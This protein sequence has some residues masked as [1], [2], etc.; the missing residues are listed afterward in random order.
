MVLE[1]NRDWVNS[2]ISSFGEII[3]RYLNSN[4][5]SLLSF[6][7]A[8]LS[9]VSF[10]R[11]YLAFGTVLMGLT[12]LFDL[13]DGIV[14][15]KNNN[16]SIKGDFLDHTID[17]AADAMIILGIAFSK[18]VDLEIGILAIIGVLMTG[19]VGTQA[20]AVGEER[21]YRGWASR[22]DI[23]TII[24]LGAISNIFFTQKIF[25]NYFFGIMMIILAFLSNMTA[26]QRAYLVW[27]KL[28]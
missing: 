23:F 27:K 26:I 22:A 18:Y 15:R 19:Y 6:V 1:E 2:R 9:S 17:R 24:S 3:G 5:I 11:N 25:S 14:A 8:V 7:F 4:Q 12:G 10:S 28:S 13:F 21:I 16:A 20:E